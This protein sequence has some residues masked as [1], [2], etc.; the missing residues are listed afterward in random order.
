VV[1]EK[2]VLPGGSTSSPGKAAE[3]AVEIAASLAAGKALRAA[4]TEVVEPVMRLE[5]TVPEVFLGAAAAAVSRRGGRIESIDSSPDGG[6]ALSGAA[7]L[8]CLF[9]FAGELRSATEGRAEYAARFSRFEAVP[10]GFT[11][12]G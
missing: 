6:S 7:P 2:L 9:G 3:H 4:G 8:R 10:P 12:F 5:I 1:L 11:D